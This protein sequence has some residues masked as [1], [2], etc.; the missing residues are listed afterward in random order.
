MG[1]ALQRRRKYIVQ[2]NFFVALALP[3]PL[4]LPARGLN[5]V[6]GQEKRELFIK[7]TLQGRLGLGL[8]PLPTLLDHRSGMSLMISFHAANAITYF[9]PLPR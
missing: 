6:R 1:V 2:L 5:F 8:G 3:P 4:L 9:S 7:Y